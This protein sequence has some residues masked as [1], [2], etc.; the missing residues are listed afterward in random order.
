MTK[1]KVLVGVIIVFSTLLSSFAFYAYQMLF[2]PNFQTEREDKPFI[3]DKGATFKDVQN[4]LYDNGY[5]TDLVSFSFLAKVMGYDEAVKPGYY[6]IKKNMSNLEAVRMLR[7]GLQEPVNITFSNVRMLSELPEKLEKNIMLTKEELSDLLLS[8]STARAYGFRQETF[9]SMFIPNTYQVYW[10]ISGKN[11]LDRM[12]AEH[13]KFWDEER[14]QKANDLGMTPAQV[15]TLASIVQAESIKPEES[16][17]IAGLYL[18]RLKRGMPLQADPTLVFAIGD[19]TIQRLLNKDRE[20]NSPYN[21]YMNAGLPPGPINMPT[22]HSI[23]AVLNY[24]NHKYLYMCAREDFSGYHAFA[25]TLQEHN[26]NAKKFQ[27][28]LNRAKIYR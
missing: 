4:A 14:L 23:D 18:N 19:F 28:A 8:D 24:E 25:A 22:I 15:A 9:I 13:E 11:L 7:A 20:V 21:T 1:R 10:T 3:I 5:V 6:L 2:T 17:I 12:K 27:D 16:A 26:V